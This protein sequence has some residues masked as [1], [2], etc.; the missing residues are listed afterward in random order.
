MTSP[1]DRGFARSER[2]AAPSTSDATA[3]EVRDGEAAV[4]ANP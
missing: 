4:D 1:S 2:A 3:A